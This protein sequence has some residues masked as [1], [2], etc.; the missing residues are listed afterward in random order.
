[1][2]KIFNKKIILIILTI[3]LLVGTSV[4]AAV[5]YE[6]NQ[7]SYTPQY[8][9]W[10][11]NNVEEALNNLYSKFNTVK[12]E[13][14]NYKTQVA[15]ALTNKGVDAS[16]E[17]SVDEIITKIDQ[18]KTSPSLSIQSASANNANT[19]YTSYLTAQN[20]FAVFCGH[21]NNNQWEIGVNVESGEYTQITN[22]SLGAGQAKMA[23][24]A[25]T[26]GPVKVRGYSHCTIGSSYNAPQ[27]MLYV[28]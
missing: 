6:A 10:N 12:T 27:V 14:E 28:W 24:Y 26:N 21:N 20:G 15:Q 2:K 1:M 4:C 11:V 22:S 23:I 13:Y 16:G 19:N 8:S 7:V 9:S 25:C 18:I 17:D 5:L 3:M